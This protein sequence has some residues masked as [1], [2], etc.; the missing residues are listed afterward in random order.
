[1]FRIVVFLTADYAGCGHFQYT[2]TEVWPLIYDPRLLERALSMYRVTW[3]VPETHAELVSNCTGTWRRIHDGREFF[4]NTPKT[5]QCIAKGLI[6][7]RLPHL[8]EQ[9]EVP[10]LLL[11]AEARFRDN[12][13][14]KGSSGLPLS[15]VCGVCA[16]LLG[17][18]SQALMHAKSELVGNFNPLQQ[19]RARMAVAVAHC[20]EKKED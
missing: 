20:L 3:D 8:V 5:A 9:A 6:A 19:T 1:M 7:A 13:F 11:T 18:K 10:G 17:D 4:Y 12:L 14:Q 2:V 15:L 16:L